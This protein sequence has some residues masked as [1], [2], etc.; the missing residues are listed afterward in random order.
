V[1]CMSGYTDDG[2]VRHGLMAGELEFL[3]KPFTPDSLGRKVR[4][5]LDGP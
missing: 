1:L 3:Q 4:E 5:L 2:V